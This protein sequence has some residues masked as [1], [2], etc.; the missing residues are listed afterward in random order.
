MSSDLW[1]WADP[2]GQQRRVRLDELRA[3]LSGGLIAPNTPVWRA[4]FQ[5]WQP[6]NEV[7]ELTTSAVGGANGVILNI[8]PPPLAM[9]AVQHQYE[10][11]AGPPSIPPAAPDGAEEEPPPPPAYVPMPARAPSLVPPPAPSSSRAIAKDAKDKSISTSLPT[12]IGGTPA[13]LVAQS[14]ARTGSSPSGS[15][16]GGAPPAFPTLPSTGASAPSASAAREGAASSPAVPSPASSSK[17]LPTAIGIPPPPE[18]SIAEPLSSNDMIEEL[19]GSMILEDTSSRDVNVPSNGSTAGPPTSAPALADGELPPPTDPIVREGEELDAIPM[20]RPGLT[21]IFEDLQAIR[22]GQPPKNKLLLGVLAVVGLSGVIMIVA[23][24]VTAFSGGS[25]STKPAASASA[26]PSSD[27]TVASASAMAPPATAI[28]KK[29]DIPPPAPK[30]ETPAPTQAAPAKLGDCTVAVEAKSVSPRAVIASGIESV[31][32]GSGIG[33]GFAATTRD[34]VAIA[35]DPASLSASSTTHGKPPIG[36]AKRVA[37]AMNGAKLVAMIDIDRKGDKLAGRRLVATSPA[38]DVGVA[39]NAI[40]WAPHNKDSY[41]KIFPLEGEGPVEALRAVPLAGAKGIAIAF[42]R[43]NGI[44]V[45]IATGDSVLS[46][47]GSLAR[48]SGLGPQVGSPALTSTGDS[49]VVAWADRAS[50]QESWQIRWTRAKIGGPAPSEAT[51]FTIPEGGLGGQAMAPA[52][53]SLG[54]GRF[55]LAWTEGP[56]QNHQVRALTMG[57]DGSPSGGPLAISG[58]GVN[59]GQPSVAVGPDGRGVVAFLAAKGKHPEVQAAGVSCAK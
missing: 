47:E 8:P 50:A 33:L 51:P 34:A 20:R 26:S 49:V 7:P 14:G 36:D 54:G 40:V 22:A 18:A 12:Q 23:L 53:A 42:R 44:F 17:S 55:L 10:S 52:L 38:I 21:M 59:A 6:A 46:P 31:A 19:S 11:Q 41:A 37:P 16:F 27:A 3:A 24:V 56:V 58:Q 32:L 4:G 45:G 35:I 1:R 9:V 5:A 30:E 48:I 15:G 2:E 25:S 39:D 57:A 43:G 29:D 13:A 28:A